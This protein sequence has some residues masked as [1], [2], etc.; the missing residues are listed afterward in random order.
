MYAIRSYYACR[1]AN[2]VLAGAY[3]LAPS[4]AL[5]AVLAGD[6]AESA[7]RQECLPLPT[8]YDLAGSLLGNEGAVGGAYCRLGAR[9]KHLCVDEF[10][11]TSFEQWAAVEPLAVEA[12]AKG[13]SLY[14]VGDAKQ[15]I[16]GWRG[17]KAELFDEVSYNF[18]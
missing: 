7:A 17:G 8:L 9:L 5:A 10:Q 16:Y 2:A 11:D 1:Q 15:A 13:G 4:V 12:L 18:V 3:A 14:C 6:L